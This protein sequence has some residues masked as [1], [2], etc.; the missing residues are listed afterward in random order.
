MENNKVGNVF[1]K[2]VL[3]NLTSSVWG[4]KRKIPSSYLNR[5]DADPDFITAHKLLV[6]K[7]SIEPIEK[8]RGAARSWLQNRSLPFPIKGVLFVPKDIIDRVDEK[9]QGFQDDFYEK[10]NEFLEKYDAIKIQSKEK[11][12][13]LY[14]PSDYPDDVNSR[15]N[16][17]WNFFIM[18]SPDNLSAISPALYARENHKFQVAMKSFEETAMATLRDNFGKM[19]GNMAEK[20]T[21]TG[22]NGKCKVFR[23]SLIGNIREFI[24]EFGYLNVVAE[25]T[26]LERLVGIA[27]AAIEGVS[28]QDLRDNKILRDGLSVSMGEILEELEKEDS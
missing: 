23:D 16:F 28:A 26:K 27:K 17:S 21:G 14:N 2:G 8:A 4:G 3:V 10:V 20:M 1:E 22:K 18:D 24:D 25:D 12:G 11:L 15:F 13:E 7:E 6:D 19:I 9:L 5:Q